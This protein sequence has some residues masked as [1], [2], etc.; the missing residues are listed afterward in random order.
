MTTRSTT[1]SLAAAL[2]VAVFLLGVMPGE[3]WSQDPAKEFARTTL[4][5]LLEHQG[6]REAVEG[7][8]DLY[9]RVFYVAYE[10]GGG[11]KVEMEGY[12]RQFFRPP[13]LLRLEEQDEDK[14]KIVKVFDGATRTGSSH[15]PGREGV[16][17]LNETDEPRQVRDLHDHL[18]R[19]RMLFGTYLLREGTEARFRRFAGAET[20]DDYWIRW[21][22]GPAAETKEYLDLRIAGG[23]LKTVRVVPTDGGEV[24][25]LVLEEPKEFGGLRFP[26]RAL[27]KR[28]LG[29]GKS[30]KV[31]ELKVVTDGLV[32]NP[33]LLD[34]TYSS[35]TVE[36]PKEPRARK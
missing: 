28:D 12:L 2:V 3:V 9:V 20:D 36:T 27:V 17:P 23:E 22:D 30:E 13:D 10:K 14:I 24:H 26:T 11:E 21:T 19:F 29:D 25:V 15:R 1:G 33:E 7:I 34:D 35:P 31:I 4:E 6:G 5:R 8:R 18:R 32:V 16:I